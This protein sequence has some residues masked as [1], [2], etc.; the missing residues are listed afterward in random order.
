MKN[1]VQNKPVQAIRITQG[2]SANPQV[3]LNSDR[4]SIMHRFGADLKIEMPINLYKK[5]LGIPF[6]KK[7]KPE[8]SNKKSS[9]RS[10]FGFVARPSI[11]LSRDGSYLIHCVVGIRV[12]K[13]INYY[14]KILGA[15]YTPKTQ[16]A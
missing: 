15:E 8:S 14:K 11:Y 16:T 9:R 7:E 12:S 6:E 2:F 1:T 10:S 13:H 4:G 5:I 3:Y